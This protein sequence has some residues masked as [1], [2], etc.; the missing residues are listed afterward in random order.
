MSVKINLLC[1]FVVRSSHTPLRG[2]LVKILI[3]DIC[4]NVIIQHQFWIQI[5][6]IQREKKWLP[7]KK[8]APQWNYKYN[9][10]R[11]NALFKWQIYILYEWIRINNTTFW[12]TIPTL[13]QSL[14]LFVMHIVYALRC[15]CISQRYRVR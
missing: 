10:I 9:R 13:Y 8:T 2:A 14:W 3:L 4:W 11:I 12:V 1:R 15:E 6:F 5:L 7:V